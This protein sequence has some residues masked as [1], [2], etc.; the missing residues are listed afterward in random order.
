M[1]LLRVLEAAAEAFVRLD[2]QHLEMKQGVKTL[3]EGF[4]ESDAL[5]KNYTYYGEEQA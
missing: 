2:R 1:K 4:Q 5:E 3:I